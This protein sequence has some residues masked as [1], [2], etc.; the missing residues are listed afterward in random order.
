M[1]F[2]KGNIMD[3]FEKRSLIY[4]NHGKGGNEIP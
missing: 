4:T 1:Y 2:D 3:M